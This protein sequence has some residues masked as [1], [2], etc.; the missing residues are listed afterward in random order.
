MVQP[1]SAE[2]FKCSKDMDVFDPGS[3]SKKIATL[4]KGTEVELSSSVDA[5]GMVSLIYTTSDGN[6]VS[7]VVRAQDVGKQAATAPQKTASGGSKSSGS[8]PPAAPAQGKDGGDVISMLKDS[9]VNERGQSVPSS[10]LE[11]SRYTLVYYS[12]H[13][14]PPCR[15]FSPSLVSFYKK[16]QDR[17]VEVVFISSDRSEADQ[18]KYMQEVGMTFPA[19]KFDA[20]K[21]SPIK[22][23]C[24]RGIPCLVA[25]DRNGKIVSDTNV[26]GQYLGPQKVLK[27]IEGLIN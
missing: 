14:C 19:L 15:T 16:Y 7:G 4:S 2:T 26:N 23:F 17:G 25:F 22:Q 20:V 1:L 24:G 10:Q 12:A 3:T 18:M 11:K 27:D 8:P 9:L 6:L 21:S 13:W 5:S